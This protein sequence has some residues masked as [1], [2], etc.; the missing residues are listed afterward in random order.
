MSTETTITESTTTTEPTT[1]PVSRAAL[2]LHNLAARE[3]TRPL[4]ATVWTF[5]G[6][7]SSADGFIAGL[8]KPK[9]ESEQPP[10]GII[11]P[12]QTAQAAVAKTSAKKRLATIER[13]AEGG[14]IST[15][16]K[17]AEQI[18]FSSPGGVDGKLDVAALLRTDVPHA[19]LVLNVENLKKVATFFSTALAGTDGMVE[20]RVWEHSRQFEFR[21]RSAEGEELTAIVMPMVM[22]GYGA[23]TAPWLF[24]APEALPEG[25]G[26]LLAHHVQQAVQ[27]GAAGTGEDR[28]AIV[29]AYLAGLGFPEENVTLALEALYTA[30]RLN[31]DEEVMGEALDAVEDEPAAT[32]AD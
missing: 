2:A 5:G 26:N 29:R 23:N 6:R 30:D 27:G 9:E 20:L 32:A 11:L 3:E 19:A 4:L 14:R 10:D 7:F 22:G 8:V 17:P 28:F 18:T 13:T 31:A 15:E 24:D 21:G 12:R 16:A 1:I 25:R